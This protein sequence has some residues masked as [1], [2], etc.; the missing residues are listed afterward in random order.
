MQNIIRRNFFIKSRKLID[1]KSFSFSSLLKLGKKNYELNNNSSRRAKGFLKISKAKFSS[2][3]EKKES[4][5]EEKH[6][7]ETQNESQEEEVKADYKLSR[8]IMWLL[9]K[10]LKWGFYL[11]V[12]LTAYNMYLLK[13]TE[14]P[15]DHKGY[16][17]FFNKRAKNLD[18]AW[19]LTYGSL[20][21]PYHSK[22]LPDA[23]E[24]VGQPPKKTLVINLSK[25]LIHYEYKFGSGFEIL[26]RPGL[27]R[28]LQEM[29]QIY[30][31]VIFGTEDSNF[32]E[33]V[34]HKL[35]QFDMNIRYKL[36]REA[37][38]L[39]KGF[40][41]KDLEFLNRDLKNVIC[42]DYK[43]EHVAY[44]PEN[45]IIIPEFNGDGKDIELLQMIVFLKEMAKA[46]VKDV[47]NELEKYG[48]YK[49]HINFYKSDPK[50][51]RFLAPKQYQ[52]VADDADL[53]A[54]KK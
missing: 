26:K 17:K 25:T 19:F 22:L 11:F 52:S 38:K 39:Q 51:K 7:E 9:K 37:T 41:I 34:C 46:D 53:L 50:Y 14:R 28:F 1:N 23:L 2:T 29:G 44:H 10:L 16:V 33:E 20:T 48:H 40:Y 21:L 12:G 54:V 5:Q 27:M 42:I 18:Y 43:P 8:K 31:L 35:D 3:E 45:T 4:K 24:Y 13:Y 36:G 49:T 6:E 30:E 15:K 47:R 32:V